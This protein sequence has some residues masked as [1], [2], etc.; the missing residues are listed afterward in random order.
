MIEIVISDQTA[1]SVQKQLLATDTEACAALLAQ[2]VRRKD[3]L[4]RLLVREIIVPNDSEYQGRSMI[5]AELS[6]A[7]VSHVASRAAARGQ[8]VIFVHSHPGKTPPVFSVVDD[9]GETALAT[10]LGARLPDR[11]A[12]A[13][14]VSEGGWACRELG[15]GRPA[16][17]ISLGEQRTTLAAPT[18]EEAIGERFDRQVRAFGQDGQRVIAGLRVAI[19]GLGGTGSL[20]AQQLAHLGVY[21]FVLLDVDHLETSNLNRVVGATPGDVG[22]SKV[23]VAAR[24]IKAINPGFEAQWNGK[25][26]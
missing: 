11:V 6:P 17:L 16:R 25:P 12:A 21:D 1:Q 23:A 9:H 13:I 15:T 14:V 18:T 10:Y 3:G 22:S 19:V 5:D 24:M 20:I 4:V 7:F 2:Q 8:S 26:S